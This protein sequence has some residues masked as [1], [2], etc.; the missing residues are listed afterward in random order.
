MLFCSLFKG[1][2]GRLEKVMSD[3]FSSFALRRD[4]DLLN[5]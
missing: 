1:G 5:V 4:S 3:F 2:R